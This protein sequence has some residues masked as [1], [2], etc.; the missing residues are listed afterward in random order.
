MPEAVLV[1]GV[2]TPFVKAGGPA[3][4][5]S[6][7]E[8]GRI[9]TRELLYRLN[10]R[11]SAV[12]EL[13]AGNVATPSDAANIGRVVALWAGIPA[14]RIA[15]SVS[16]NCASG[17][18]AVSQAVARIEAGRAK[19]VVAL[20]VESMSSIPVL[21][22]PRLVEIFRQYTSSKSMWA[23]LKAL[24]KL[25]PRDLKPHLALV[26]GLTDP[27]SGMIMGLTAEKLAREFGISRQRQDEFA[28]QS[29]LKAA[30]AWEAGEFDDEVV[31]IFPPPELNA[32]TEDVGFRRG[33]TIE[34]LAKLK[35]YFDRKFGTVTVGNSSQVTD[36][37]VAI[38]VM[39]KELALS[40]GYE[41]LGRIVDHAYA[42]CDPSRMGLGPVFATAKLFRRLGG[43]KLADVDLFELNEAFA[44]QVLAC[45]DAFASKTFAEEKLGMSQPLGEIDPQRLNVKGGAIALGHPVGAS[46]AR[47]LLTLLMELKRRDLSRGLATLCVGG[48][49]G[50]AFVVERLAA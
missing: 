25:R 49:Q 29:H 19:T 28:L 32:V 4:F 34:A 7:A 18:E 21:W 9:A 26:E 50:G 44:A 37:A 27:V 13:I 33:Q 38:L 6:A 39:E 45:L 46:G 5:T 14:D 43:T 17:F 10:L 3:R 1:S 2:R 30:K 24:A 36:G 40:M 11:P 47:L 16:R 12:D 35:P 22:R 42:G 48:G 41:P 15:H 31:P 8:L 20:G 23:R